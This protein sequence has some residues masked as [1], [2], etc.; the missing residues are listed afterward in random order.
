M[1]MMM[2]AML[3]MFVLF[4]FSI[5]SLC[6][7]SAISMLHFK[8]NLPCSNLCKTNLQS[9]IFFLSPP[10][11][12]LSSSAIFSPLSSP[13]IQRCI[14]SPL[15]FSSWFITLRKFCACQFRFVLIRKTD[16]STVGKNMKARKKVKEKKRKDENKRKMR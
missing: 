12:F 15:P 5:S 8:F 13:T 2:V 4:M 14:S 11:L 3:A 10:C 6:S 7:L 16:A 9:F 1:M